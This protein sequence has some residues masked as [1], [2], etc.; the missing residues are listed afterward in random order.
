MFH[1]LKCFACLLVL[2]PSLC[3]GQKNPSA[4]LE[5]LKWQEGPASGAIGTKATI[6]IP[7]G[8]VFLGERDTARFLELMGNPPPANNYLI[9]P[10]ELNWFAVFRFDETG[11]IKDDERIDPDSLLKQLKQSDESDNEER[12]RLGMSALYTEGWQVLPHY[13]VATKQLEWGIRVR[14]ESG[15]KNVNYT[16]RL[17]SRTGVMSAILVANTET[18]D[19]DTR[20][21][22]TALKNFSFVS[23]EKYSEFKPGDHVAE[24]GLAA[25]ILG[26]AAA[27][28]TKKGFWAVLVGFLVAFK[29]LL[30]GLGIA[31]IAALGRI[32][33]KKQGPR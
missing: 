16:S 30:V 17:L 21:F 13:D 29:K 19:N 32:F 6:Q 8:Y 26:G 9:A 23:G 25:L 24:F 28:A 18:L 11:F 4:G 7:R 27:V 2:V 31:A 22:K 14:D 12:R 15:V 20:E 3:V 10:K 33:R 1:W 5:K